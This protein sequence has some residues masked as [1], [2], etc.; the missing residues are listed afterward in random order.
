MCGLLL[1][2]CCLAWMQ[3]PFLGGLASGALVLIGLLL[4]SLG[5]CDIGVDSPSFSDS[6]IVRH[7]GDQLLLTGSPNDLDDYAMGP[8][9]V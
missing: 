1:S 3:G 9:K 5:V 7:S 4:S 6:F 2:C 8:C